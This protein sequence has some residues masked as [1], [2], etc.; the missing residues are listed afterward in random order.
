VLVRK[1]NDNIVMENEELRKSG[2]NDLE[3]LYVRVGYGKVL[4][5]HV[6]RAVEPEAK[7]I[8]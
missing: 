3:D 8:H 5:K 7:T 6:V 1:L 4:P 2:A